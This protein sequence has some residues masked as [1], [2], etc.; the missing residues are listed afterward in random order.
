MLN[1][2]IKCLRGYI[3]Y[4]LFAFN[5]FYLKYV[6]CVNYVKYALYAYIYLIT[7]ARFKRDRIAKEFPISLVD[8]SI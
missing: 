2:Q 8:F 3:K 6:F 7:V 5:A 4:V 1:V